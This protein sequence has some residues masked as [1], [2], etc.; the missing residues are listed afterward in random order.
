MVTI[1]CAC[2]ERSLAHIPLDPAYE[3]E[4][5]AFM[6]ELNDFMKDRGYL[7][8]RIAILVA[9]TSPCSRSLITKIPQLGHREI[10]LCMLYKQVQSPIN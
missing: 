1:R 7:A 9:L 8:N 5:K 3:D 6:V 4:R 2:I 10:D